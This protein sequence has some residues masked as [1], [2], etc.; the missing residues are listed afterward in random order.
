MK[1]GLKIL[2]KVI[3]IFLLIVVGLTAIRLIIGMFNSSISEKNQMQASDLDEG[4]EI[5]QKNSDELFFLFAGVDSNGEETGT[6]TD[7]LMLV[8]CNKLTKD[9]KI[10]SIPRDTRVYIDGKLDKINAAHSY[11]GIP[12]TIKTIREFMGVDLDYFLQV[13]FEG[14]VDGVDA[15]GGIDIDVDQRVADA[16]RMNP[17]VHNF[18]G[19]KAL[20]YV[21]FRKGYGDADLGRIKT[22]QDFVASFIKQA[23]KP[24]NIFKL[25]KV[26]MAM[27][28]NMET[29]IPFSTLFSFA[30]DFKNISSANI[31]T[32]TIDGNPEMIGGTS[33][34]IPSSSSILNLRNTLLYNYINK[35]Y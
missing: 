34:Y 2:L 10:I 29:N 9:I 8:L 33:Y 35:D 3:I 15:L 7:T 17:G 5:I 14:V 32:Y 26:Y 31:S 22:Q 28:N 19:E 13:S 20:W 6:R 12:L 11:G 25:P 27:S 21:R 30:W 1:K 4:N 18:D 23:L 16:M 24:K